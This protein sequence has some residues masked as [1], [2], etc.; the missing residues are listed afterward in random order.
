MEYYPAT[1]KNEI[2]PFVTTQM[3]PEGYAKGTKSD[4][5]KTLIT[6]MGSTTYDKCHLHTE[7]KKLRTK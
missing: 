5:D 4:K 6:C 7:A 3:D 2:L 1:K